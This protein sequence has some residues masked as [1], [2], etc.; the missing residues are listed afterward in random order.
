M[1]YILQIAPELLFYLLISVGFNLLLFIPAFIF[2]TDK[3]TDIS[4]SIS[5][6]F[7]AVM[8]FLSEEGRNMW[9]V[10]FLLTIVL[11]AFRLGGYLLYRVIKMKKDARFDKM[12]NNFLKFGSFWLLQGITVWFVM[13]PALLFFLSENPVAIDTTSKIIFIIGVWIWSEGLTLETFSDIQKFKYIQKSKKEG[14]KRHW[15]DVG[16]WKYIRHPNYLG[17]VIVWVG[18]YIAVISRVNFAAAILALIGPIFIYSM[19]RYVS[20]VPMLEKKADERYGDD[21]EYQKYKEETSL[22]VPFV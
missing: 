2:K 14:R 18:V 11:W 6:V 4:Y 12:R 16:F 17:E 15:I 8:A 20:G 22:L 9:E 10:V 1:N 13:I 3:L 5:F 19:I 21:P 7:L